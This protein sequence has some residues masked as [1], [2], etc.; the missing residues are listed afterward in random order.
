MS[1]APQRERPDKP[2]VTRMLREPAQENIVNTGF[3]GAKNISIYCVFS[4]ESFKKRG[5]TYLT[6][7]GQYETEKKLQG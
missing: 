4:S 7:F 5:N 2:K 6:I 1:T 3:R